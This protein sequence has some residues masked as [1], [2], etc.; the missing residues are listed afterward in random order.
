MEVKTWIL[1]SVIVVIILSYLKS[2][3]SKEDGSVSKILEVYTLV[4]VKFYGETIRKLV[5]G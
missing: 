3:E 2:S 1:P 5:I 4:L